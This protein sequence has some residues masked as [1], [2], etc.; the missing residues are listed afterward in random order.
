MLSAPLP[1]STQ[2]YNFIKQVRIINLYMKVQILT[3]LPNSQV[4]DHL[5]DRHLNH[6]EKYRV[7]VLFYC[8]FNQGKASDI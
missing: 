1:P 8:F 7:E 2:W 4:D 5:C 6:L 3:P